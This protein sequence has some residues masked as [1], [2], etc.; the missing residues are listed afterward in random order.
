MAETVGLTRRGLIGAAAAT[1]AVGL[2]RRARAAEPIRIGM[3]L[4]L[5]GPGGEIGQQMRHGA[6]F[7]AKQQNAAGGVLGRAIE[8]IVEDTG[9]DPATCVRKAQEVVERH[10]CRLLMGMTFSSEALAVVPRL[11]EWNAIFGYQKG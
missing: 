3:P 5:T 7:W 4:A 1:A 9:G 6:E 2:A 8:L 11:A 10:G